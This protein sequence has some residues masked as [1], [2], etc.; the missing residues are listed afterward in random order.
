MRP[1]EWEPFRA[2]RLH[3]LQSEPGV[4]LMSYAKESAQTDDEWRELLR[5]DEKKQ[6]FGLFDGERLVGITA[7]FTWRLDPSEKTAV[8]AM[9]YIAPEYRKRGFSRLL[10]NARLDWVRA[11]AQ[12]EKIVVSHRVSNEISAKANR[13]FGFEFVRTESKNWPDGTT[14][15]EL[16]YELR[17][18]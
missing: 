14:E 7:A 1:D 16:V 8:F 9:S 17:I 18:R 6:V 10:Y 15:D 4:F 5:G 2:M 13:P 11:H 3:A 12:V